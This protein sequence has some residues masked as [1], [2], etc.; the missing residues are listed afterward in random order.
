MLL[1]KPNRAIAQTLNLSEHTVKEHVTALL[2]RLEA[3]NRVELI[4]RMHGIEI[5]LS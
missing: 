4:T 2:Q 3:S 1:G 5:E